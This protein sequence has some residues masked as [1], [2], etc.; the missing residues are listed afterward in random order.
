MTISDD[1][2]LA[3]TPE[4]RRDLTKRLAELNSPHLKPHPS[5]RRVVLFVTIAATVF[6]IAWI[7]LL[8]ISLPHRYVAHH[9]V[10]TWV[11]FDVAELAFLAITAYFALRRRQA[12]VL[13]AFAAA[14]L[15]VC[16]AWFDLMTASTSADRVGAI[17]SALFGELPIAALLFVMS[18]WLLSQSLRRA[19]ALAGHDDHPVSFFHMPMQVEFEHGPP[20][21]RSAG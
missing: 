12:F 18:W 21:E 15:L 13:T 14:A 3:M 6:L 20:P 7:P 19:Y 10:L 16:D 1:Q 17:I 11:G 8:A 5:R 9:W 4:E 2:L